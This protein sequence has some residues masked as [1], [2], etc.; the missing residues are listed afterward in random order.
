MVR[1]F[2]GFIFT[3]PRDTAV[4]L[5]KNL[6]SLGF[7]LAQGLFTLLCFFWISQ[8]IDGQVLRQQLHSLHWGWAA[9]GIISFWLQLLLWAW[10]W[11][12]MLIAAAGQQKNLSPTNR[13][14]LL[15][16]YAYY[17]IGAFFNQALPGNISGDVLRG[18]YVRPWVGGLSL[19]IGLVL[20]ERLLGLGALL[21]LA[22]V[23]ALGL[24]SQLD[25][26]PGM[27]WLLALLCGG[28]LFGLWVVA[29]LPLPKLPFAIWDKIRGK[30]LDTRAVLVTTLK[31]RALLQKILAISLIGQLVTVVTIGA[32]AWALG[33][34]LPLSSL[35]VVWPVTSVLLT[36]PIS[37]AGWGLR[38]GVLVFFLTRQGLSVES[39]LALSLLNGVTIL[40]ASL[41][42]GLLWW[43]MP[44]AKLAS[45]KNLQ[46]AVPVVE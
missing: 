40:L 36:L 7:K 10:R 12:I 35:L 2:G 37:L 32:N 29:K 38:E 4:A 42:G 30:L 25:A 46:H 18:L 20:V 39:A 15:K 3:L 16:L 5:S 6:K 45:D 26:L 28:Y 24:T 33:M 8:K 27:G 14:P 41:P 17:H 1:I 21:G 44:P 43:A 23:S 34:T 31:N 22:G 13:P 9:V 11:R 19:S